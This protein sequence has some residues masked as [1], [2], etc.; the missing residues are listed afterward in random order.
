MKK[1]FLILA[2]ISV[3]LSAQQLEKSLL[4]KISGNGIEEA[5]YLFGTIHLSCDATLPEKVVKA[6]DETN[7]LYLELDMSDPSMQQKMMSNMMM[8]EGKTLS[9]II[10]PEDFNVLNDFLQ[11]KLGYT[12]AMLNTVKPFIITSMFYPSLLDC[13]I[14]SIEESL[15]TITKQQN[16]KVLGLETVEEQLK[17][18][19]EI[20]YEVQAKELVKSAKNNLE[21]DK[22][23]YE[24]LLKIYASENIEALY[25]AILDS[26]NEVNSNY[27]EKLLSNRNKNW[28]PIIEKTMKEQP[29]FF[30]VGAAHLGGAQGVIN[31]L[32]EKGYKVEAVLN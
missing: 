21:N 2:F 19:D 22:Q 1:L 24:S 13:E 27:E 29:T 6:L 23:E 18:F 7:Q 26:E 15:M 3:Q 12:L 32:L 5:S 30:G 16:E 20:P 8:T 31:L 17:V 25:Q 9:E 10:T 11:K 28:I 14:K 4:W